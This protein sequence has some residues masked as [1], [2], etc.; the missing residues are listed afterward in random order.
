MVDIL[1]AT[2]YETIELRHSRQN[3]E[4]HCLGNLK[5]E[6][7]SKVE[8]MTKDVRCSGAADELFL[9]ALNYVICGERLGTSNTG[10]NSLSYLTSI[11]EGSNE[12]PNI[13]P[14]NN[15]HIQYTGYACSGGRS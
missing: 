8:K 4:S 2:S 9:A 1:G 13:P 5:E 3:L 10:V 6:L 12:R 11:F 7:T 15:R 14:W